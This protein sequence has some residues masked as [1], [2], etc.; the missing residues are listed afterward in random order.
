VAAWFSRVATDREL[1]SAYL[2]VR[3]AG[4]AARLRI[5]P[6]ACDD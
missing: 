2:G 1:V 3:D 5:D 4:L 6:P